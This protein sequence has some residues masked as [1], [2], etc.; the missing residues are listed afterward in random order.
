M[1][2]EPAKAN[3]LSDQQPEW[4]EESELEEPFTGSIYAITSDL[5]LAFNLEIQARVVG[6]GD[7][8]FC[9]WLYPRGHTRSHSEHGR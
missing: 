7:W 2:S 5:N 4:Q 3:E 6:N 8:G 1:A 9:W